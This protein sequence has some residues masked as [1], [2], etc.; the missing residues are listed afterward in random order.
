MGGSGKLE[1][2]GCA[3]VPKAAALRYR[4]ASLDA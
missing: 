1:A 2:I 3:G 4:Q